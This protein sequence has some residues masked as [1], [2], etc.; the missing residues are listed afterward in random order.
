MVELLKKILHKNKHLVYPQLEQDPKQHNSIG[1]PAFS[2]LEGVDCGLRK[3][4]NP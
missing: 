4:K 2:D 1:E 3:T